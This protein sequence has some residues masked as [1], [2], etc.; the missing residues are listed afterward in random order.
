MNWLAMILFVLSFLAILYVLQGYT[1][2]FTSLTPGKYSNADINDNL[3]LGGIYPE[4]N[5]NLVDRKMN[6]EIAGKMFYKN[7]VEM[8]SYE[9]KTNNK[10][11]WENPDNGTC[12]RFDMCGLYTNKSF[13][14]HIIQNTKEETSKCNMV[15]ESAKAFEK[16]RVNMYAI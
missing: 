3:L 7:N 4:N 13:T 14:P 12:V 6:S 16:A 9:Q 8:S 15:D 5:V 11:Y 1:E 10:R 2:A